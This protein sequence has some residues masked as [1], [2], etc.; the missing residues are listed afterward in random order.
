MALMMIESSQGVRNAAAIAAVPGVAGFYVGP[1]DLSNSLG[2]A[3]SDPEVE[4]AIQTIVSVCV[5][6]GIAC[7][8]TANATDMPRRIEQGF[9]I[10]GAGRAGGGL[11]AG[12]AEAVRV[13]RSAR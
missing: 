9:T 5:T 12:N 4:E 11:T 13:G 6:Q 3:R 7:G 8:I 2:I 1:S 10:L